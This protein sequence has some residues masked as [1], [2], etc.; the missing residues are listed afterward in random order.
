MG[1]Q[2]VARPLPTHRLV[3]MLNYAKTSGGG[4]VVDVPVHVFLTFG[5][6]WK[7]KGHGDPCLEWESNP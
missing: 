1:D 3:P 4:G 7:Q 6:G 5:T 2:P